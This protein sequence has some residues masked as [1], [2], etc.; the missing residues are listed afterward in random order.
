MTNAPEIEALEGP[1]WKRRLQHLARRMSSDACPIVAGQPFGQTT[2]RADATR[3]NSTT[4][5]QSYVDEAKKPAHN[6]LS[7][8]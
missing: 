2:L 4:V 8:G 6:F 1:T 5:D 7:T 3:H